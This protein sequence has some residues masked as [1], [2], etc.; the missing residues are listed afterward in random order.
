LEEL[1]VDGKIILKENLTKHDGIVWIG[2]VWP[3][4]GTT[5][6]LNSSVFWVI[7]RHEVV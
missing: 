2:F 4:I 1:P 7:K 5:G 6:L 3:T